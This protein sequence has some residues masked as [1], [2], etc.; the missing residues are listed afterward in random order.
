M[1]LT[2]TFFHC[3]EQ[4]LEYLD[5]LLFNGFVL[6]GIQCEMAGEGLGLNLALEVKVFGLSKGIALGLQTVRM[7]NVLSLVSM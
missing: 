5:I 3:K 6:L 7:S 2:E 4:F 1:F